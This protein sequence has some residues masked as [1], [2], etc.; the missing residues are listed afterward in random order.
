[1][2]LERFF[3]RQE[4]LRTK[5]RREGQTLTTL[6]L[7]TISHD[8]QILTKVDESKV[9]AEA[10]IYNTAGDYFISDYNVPFKFDS[11]YRDVLIDIPSLFD[12]QDLINGE[13]KVSFSFLSPLIGDIQTLPFFLEE[14]SP[15]RTEVK[16]TVKDSYQQEFPEVKNSVKQ[17]QQVA[18]Y[19][20]SQG[21]LNNI[22]LNF[23]ENRIIQIVN[24]KTECRDS[25]LDAP[26][27]P[28]VAGSCDELV[29]YCKL[30]T[31]LLEEIQETESCFVAFKV[32]NDYVSTFLLLPEQAADSC[33]LLRGPNFDTPY[34]NLENSNQTGVQY[35]NALL[36]ANPD[37]KDRLIR[38]IFSGSNSVNLNL[39]WSQFSNFVIYGSAEERLK[40]YNYKVKL[41]EYYTSQSKALL[42]TAGTSSLT[43]VNAYNT[44]LKDR[45]QRVKGD[46]DPFEKFLFYETGSNFTH[47][48][49]GSLTAAP[50]YI[51]GSSIINYPTTS[52]QYINWYVSAS[53]EAAEYDRTNLSSL[54]FNTPDHILRDPNNSEYITFIHMIGQHFDNM[55][56]F[57]RKLTSIHV[58]DEHPKYGIPNEL[59][60]YYAQSLG[61]KI[62]NTRTLSD[63][64]LYKLGTDNSGSYSAPSGSLVSLSHQN[65][66][67]QVW[68][69]IVNNLPHLL[70][71]KGTERS[72]KALFS[73][74]GI[75][76]TLISVKEYGGPAA[77]DD[78]PESKPSTIEQR[79]QYLLN[80]NGNQYIKLPRTLVSS[81]FY[82]NPLIPSTVE[83]RF[84][85]NYTTAPSM[86]LWAIEEES[87]KTVLHNL[88][89]VNYSG[90]I[91]GQ[92]TY[93]YLRYTATTGSSGNLSYISETGS[94][95]P[96]Y[97]NDIWTVRLHTNQPLY[98]GSSFDGTINI[99]YAKAS[100]IVD[101]RVSLSS[102]FE[103]S[104]N[105][106]SL[107]YSLGAQTGV[108]HDIIVGGTTGSN[109]VRFSGSIQAYREY[110]EPF[111]DNIFRDH[112]L[113]PGSYA[114]THFSSS[115]TSLYRYYP[116]GLEALRYNHSLYSEVSSSHPNQKLGTGTTAS[117]FNFTGDQTTQYSG[118]SEVYYVRRPSIGGNNVKG[119]KI[120]LEK[121]ELDGDLSVSRRAEVSMFDRQQ[122]DSNRLAIVFSPTDQVNRD[123]SNQF[124]PYNFEDFIGD[125]SHR[126][127]LE[128]PD[129][130][131]ARTEYF[132]KYTRANDIG[133]YI[134][135]F[136]LY[137]YTV[138]EQLKQLIPARANLI[139]GVLVEPSLLERPKIE[140]KDPSISF[141]DKDTTLQGVDGQI[142]S[143]YI[144]I[145][146]AVLS[147][148][149]EVEVERSKEQ[150]VLNLDFYTPEIEREK[151]KGEA[152]VEVGIELERNK[153]T[154][155]IEVKAIR[156][157][158]STGVR[159]YSA[160]VEKQDTFT[161]NGSSLISQS[162]IDLSV[163]E[164]QG[165]FL[166]DL[167]GETGAYDRRLTANSSNN[168]E[169][170]GIGNY[171]ISASNYYINTTEPSIT[172]PYKLTPS[173]LTDFL[174]KYNYT[175][176]EDD[177]TIYRKN[178][179][180]TIPITIV[181]GSRTYSNIKT[182]EYFYS[183]SGEF[184]VGITSPNMLESPVYIANRT[185][186][187]SIYNRE[188]DY[189]IN[190][191]YNAFY[192]S[193]LK[194]ANYQFIE[195]SA[196]ANS[197][198]KG[199]KIEGTDINTDS[200]QTIKG[201]PVVIV[202]IINDN[203]TII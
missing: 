53:A 8:T 183:S 160:E 164:P 75:P 129:L 50:K 167:S 131:S 5:Q 137:D 72:I 76:F 38:E 114:G 150:V 36:D 92:E 99:E 158:E 3:N 78:T 89:L 64:W 138:F 41:I 154:T 60:P 83:F 35:W 177:S 4:L 175:I 185:G 171:F 2:S 136:S 42:T 139:T 107:Y 74:Y 54:Y 80:L 32:L 9:L 49:T 14:I 125:P 23:G 81:S 103:I 95:L 198:F 61:W 186:S 67:Y 165:S 26:C 197:R 157:D 169:Q 121:S 96:L 1:M 86:S 40:N 44:T 21:L 193:S 33:N 39:D 20:K 135:I 122:K 153:N 148:S 132:K 118:L 182:T 102:S 52:S 45:I 56:A 101:A 149:F 166:G 51:A 195:E 190:K 192:S 28:N 203:R 128:Y 141:L 191:E 55:Y 71:T 202:K 59:L 73:S 181:T 112:I 82:E 29:I 62:Q 126:G 11:K 70:K 184:V 152:P 88:E 116:L 187:K 134:E 123:I 34:T 124:G 117:F 68:R 97:D 106:S 143:N 174:Q 194:D 110:F 94:L 48:V 196:V 63:L 16:L 6:D 105:S 91:Y 108:Q 111:P 155:S 199:S 30:Y 58:R 37:T 145:P 176:F 109:N 159:T 19:L 84:K 69:R 47:A 22:V 120:R 151:N 100:D 25:V 93:G 173:E 146:Q 170:Y 31:P 65:L 172:S 43:T 156:I 115:F 104:A 66:S 147:S 119:N 200:N 18:G 144:A 87:T 179:A 188:R 168:T 15:D 46:F 98:S 180:G 162:S 27:N 10:H 161:I 17:F 130:Y 189:A 90:S 201:G 140:R 85:T 133:K 12:R 57:I 7:S 142:N 79:F 178:T 13:Y 113:N 163:V 24:A 77:Q 127:K